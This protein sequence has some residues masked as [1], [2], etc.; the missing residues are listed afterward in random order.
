MLRSSRMLARRRSQNEAQ[1]NVPAVFQRI[2]RKLRVDREPLM[3][4]CLINL[5][6]KESDLVL[7]AELATQLSA[8]KTAREGFKELANQLL[9]ILA[10]EAALEGSSSS[11]EVATKVGMA[12][13]FRV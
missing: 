6:M 12:P 11:P 8:H 13:P 10:Q 4:V 2:L 3:L 5:A 1:H 9:K 7:A